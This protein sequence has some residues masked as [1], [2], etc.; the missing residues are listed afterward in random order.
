MYMYY[1]RDWGNAVLI[2][3][4]ITGANEL[5]GSFVVC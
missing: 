3:L 5:D 2:I 4:I 1:S